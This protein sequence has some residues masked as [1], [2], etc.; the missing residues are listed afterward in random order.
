MPPQKKAEVDALIS[1]L[2]AAGRS[3]QPRPLQNPLLFG[4]Y[5]VAYT[6]SGEDQSGQRECSRAPTAA[7]MLCHALMKLCSLASCAA[8]AADSSRSLQLATT[9]LYSFCPLSAQQC[10]QQ[11]HSAGCSQQHTRWLP[12]DMASPASC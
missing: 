12:G 6:S 8:A 5:N 1:Q 7:H 11:P 3:Q 9:M 10:S 2:E 4:N